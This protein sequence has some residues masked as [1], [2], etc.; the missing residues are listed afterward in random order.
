MILTREIAESEKILLEDI[1]AAAYTFPLDRPESDGT[2]EWSATT[3]VL[4]TVR[5]GGKT[6]IGY[7]YVSA[8]AITVVYDFL[9]PAIVNRNVMNVNELH[10]AMT[11]AI[12][13]QGQCGIAM[14]ALSAVDIALWDLKAKVLEIPLYTLLSPAKGKID[15]YG[16]GGF[17]SYSKGE[18]QHQLA[19]WVEDGIPKVKIKIGRDIESD[20]KRVTWSRQAIGNYTELYVDANGAYS[21]KQALAQ[22]KLFEASGVTWFEEP[23]VASD[24]KALNFL[25]KQ[26]SPL[27]R[28]VGG[29][30]GFSLSDFL[31]MLVDETVDVLQADATRC[32]G[33]TGFVNAGRLA[34]AFHTPLSSHCAPTIHIGAAMSLTNF[35]VLEYFHDHVQ[36]ES[37][38][39]DGFVIPQEGS[40]KPDPSR[41]GL[42]IE[43]KWQDAARFKVY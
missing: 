27:M 11:S 20:V 23:V 6:G 32:G 19:Q 2:L 10:A 37:K 8:A 1:Q 35:S 21:A 36:I 31:S 22:S 26:V 41:P 30:Y 15:V 43:F 4:V 3:M 17:T 28:I 24:H 12:R 13:N 34:E 25:R 5:A 42:G 29:E 40:L 14:M 18:L 38:Y 33:I 39:L 9:K 16:S 7:S